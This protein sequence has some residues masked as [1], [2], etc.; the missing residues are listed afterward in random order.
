MHLLVLLACDGDP[1]EREPTA[2]P[3]AIELDAQNLLVPIDGDGALV[4]TIT[5][6]A[7]NVLD[8]DA[9]W[10]IEDT[11]VLSVDDGTVLPQGVIAST[12]VHAEI[13]GI[14]SD[15]VLVYVARPAPDAILVADSD[16]VEG[17]TLV[18][19]DSVEEIHDIT[20]SMTLDISSPQVG[21]LVLG[22]QDGMTPGRVVS[23]SE[24][25]DGVEVELTYA[26]ID[27]AFE[28]LSISGTTDYVTFAESETFIG[29]SVGRL[30][31]GGMDCV[32]G[33]GGDDAFTITDTSFEVDHALDTRFDL[34][35]ASFTVEKAEFV[36]EGELGIEASI[37][38]ELGEDVK[39]SVT[40]GAETPLYGVF[41]LP[42]VLGGPIIQ[43]YVPVYA[44]FSAEAE[45]I[46]YGPEVGLDFRGDVEVSAGL[47]YE[48]GEFLDVNSMSA[49][50]ELTPSITA[51]EDD[52]RLKTSLWP[53]ISIGV[54]PGI[55]TVPT[56]KYFSIVEA[57]TGPEIAADLAHELVQIEDPDYASSFGV[58][59]KWTVGPPQNVTDSLNAQLRA[60]RW[61]LGRLGGNLTAALTYS[62]ST[63]LWNTPGGDLSIGNV[64][65]VDGELVLDDVAGIATPFGDFNVVDSVSFRT[66]DQATDTI[67][68]IA[69]ESTSSVDQTDYSFSWAAP[70]P[71]E[72]VTVYA[73]FAETPFVDTPLELDVVD[74]RCSP[75]SMVVESVTLPTDA[76]GDGV[77]LDEAMYEQYEVLE[78]LAIYY[79]AERDYWISQYDYYIATGQY[80]AA[81]SAYSLWE[82][83]D[84]VATN[85]TNE[86][87]GVATTYAAVAD[88]ENGALAFRGGA[89]SDDHSTTLAE[90]TAGTLEAGTIEGSPAYEDMG[91]SEHTWLYAPTA[92]DVYPLLWMWD[93]KWGRR[94]DDTLF[95]R[96][97]GFTAVAAY[98]NE[99]TFTITWDG[100]TWASGDMTALMA[101]VAEDETVFDAT[102]T[103]EI[104][105]QGLG[106][107]R[108]TF[109]S[110]DKTAT[111]EGTML[112]MTVRLED[113][114]GSCPDE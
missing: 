72:A 40:C 30:R 14:A 17:P 99:P 9:T 51:P 109:P 95:V 81:A 90:F 68:E 21:D 23:V 79:G 67:T 65:P 12:L 36:V 38:A 15:P 42:P 70:T 26:P 6:E 54:G 102:H 43:G 33:A 69:N 46:H 113:A 18:S 104:A 62:D 22:R 24:A 97:E 28:D 47:H 87:V 1:A 66:Y 34:V 11:T 32:V 91:S 86:L 58:N 74:L 64:D 50:M 85:L 2:V 16:I 13:D 78:A 100:T 88:A 73:A 63:P 59:L 80:S 53:F 44:G 57:N 92:A 37:A 110:M 20:F 82:Y 31:F 35:V 98:I 93:W 45:T 52:D 106:Y 75:V 41:P 105:V 29:F 76:T 39:G 5:D 7:G 4:A 107:D 3:F 94:L 27:E 89:E 111:V 96:S 60:I 48:G 19:D 8:L 61:I 56:P 77:D 49:S 108:A 101:S 10:V 112:S 84:V 55:P 114:G 103:I 25:S 71:E 83:Y